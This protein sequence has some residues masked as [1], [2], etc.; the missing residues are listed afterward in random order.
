MIFLED[1]FRSISKNVPH[2]KHAVS[3]KIE[4]LDLRHLGNKVQSAYLLSLASVIK[5]MIP[6]LIGA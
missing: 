1:P 2:E 5:L 3:H 6:E 4:C